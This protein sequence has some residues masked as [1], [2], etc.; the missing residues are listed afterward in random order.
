[1][2]SLFTAMIDARIRTRREVE[3]PFGP[4]KAVHLMEPGS[5]P[6][7]QRIPG[8]NPCSCRGRPAQGGFGS[9]SSSTSP[10][11]RRT[12]SRA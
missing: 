12:A 10:G 7:H 3:L 4:G 6:G 1:M 9:S 8:D 2:R 11:A 5:S